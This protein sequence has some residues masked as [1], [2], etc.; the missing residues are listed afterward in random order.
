MCQGW[1]QE[2][3]LDV[4][5]MRLYSIYGPGERPHRLFPRLWKAF[6]KNQAMD[7]V[8]GVHDFLY[9]DDTVD[10]IVQVASSDQ[11]LAGEIINV[12]SGIQTT[13]K[14]V[15]E[16]FETVTGHSAPVNFCPD[17]FVTQPVW[18][19]DNHM[20]RTRYQWSPRFDLTAGIQDF[21]QRAHYE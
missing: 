17:R 18:Q 12:C 8:D 13:N 5:T 16:I 2:F 19:G 7:L 21:L 4:V 6:R 9:I 10:A 11:R 15:L 1:A 14:D 3:D 20:L